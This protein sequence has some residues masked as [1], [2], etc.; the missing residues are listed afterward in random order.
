[1]PVSIV[2]LNPAADDS[3]GQPELVDAPLVEVPVWLAK[4]RAQGSA[5]VAT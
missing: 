5:S 2:N 4:R 1:M 3:D